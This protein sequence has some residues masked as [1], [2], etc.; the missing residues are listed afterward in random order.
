MR[1]GESVQMEIP[2]VGTFM[3]RGGIAAVSFQDNFSEETRGM[4]AKNHTV[5]NLFANSSNRLNMQI[6]DEGKA[7]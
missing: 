6:H 7:K 3:V 2:F 1:K 5:N 4:T